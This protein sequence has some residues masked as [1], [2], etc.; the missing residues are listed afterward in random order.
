[1]INDR[2]FEMGKAMMTGWFVEDG[3]SISS[4]EAKRVWDQV[5]AFLAAGGYAM[6][7]QAAPGDL[8]KNYDPHRRIFELVQER[9]ALRAAVNQLIVAGNGVAEIWSPYAL[10]RG[11]WDRAVAAAREVM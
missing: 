4:E 1:M 11:T 9:D 5:D 2:R 8:I 3:N 6:E 7:E 10:V